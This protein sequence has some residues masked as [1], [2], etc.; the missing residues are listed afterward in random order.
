[1]E[2]GRFIVYEAGPIL[3]LTLFMV[4]WAVRPMLWGGYDFSLGVLY[5]FCLRGIRVYVLFGCG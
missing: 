2:G 4:V 3:G 1:M 5:V